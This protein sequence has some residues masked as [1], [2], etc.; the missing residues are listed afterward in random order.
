MPIRTTCI[1]AFP[2]PDYVPI[3]DWFQVDLGAADYADDV[4]SR[5]TDDPAHDAT[6][7]RATAQ[8]VQ[9]QIDAGIHIVTDGEQRRE[10]YVHY[11]C[12][13]FAGFDFDNLERRVLR[14]GAYDCVLPAIRSPVVA[15]EPVLPRDWREAQAAARDVPV[16]ITLP[17]PMTIMDSTADCHYDDP[18]RLARDLAD[19]LNAEV[20]ALSDAGCQ[21]IQIDEP[22]FARKP[23]DAAAFGFDAL[24]RTLHGTQATTTVHM[25]CGYPDRL[26]NPDYPK[27]DHAVYHALVDALDGVVDMISIEDCHCHND[28]TLFER[29]KRSTAVVGFV[30]VAVSGVEPIDAITARMRDILQILPPDRLIGAP[31]CGLGFL[32]TDLALRKLKNLSVAAN[33]V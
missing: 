32:G 15:G 23:D 31:D 11:Q 5:W 4:V 16:K 21:H 12:R 28:L 7:A 18:A 26:D 1:G 33:E 19:A 2:K 10:N 6:F 29:F 22:V 8:V 27:A 20:H 17:G 24:A 3:K 25:C 9:A 14:N 13:Q 30:D